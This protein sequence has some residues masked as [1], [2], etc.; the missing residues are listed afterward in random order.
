[1]R[2]KSKLASLA[3]VLRGPSKLDLRRKV[4]LITGGS[5]G[6]GIELAR[7]F[8]KENAR[9]AVCARTVID[10]EGALRELGQRDVDDCVLGLVCDV[11]DRKAIAAT[12]DV[13]A[14]H[15]GRIDVLVN[16][17]GPFWSDPPAPW[18]APISSAEWR[19]T[20]GVRSTPSPPCYAICAQSVAGAS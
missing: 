12:V 19:P 8:L 13:V 14:K 7:R 11:M 9:V 15:W 2:T 18:L 4:V 20:F 6:L 17:A 16:N 1:M 3:A 5:R 10:V